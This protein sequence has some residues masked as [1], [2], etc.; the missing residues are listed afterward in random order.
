[1]RRLLVALGL[2]AATLAGSAAV[3][4]AAGPTGDAATIAYVRAVDANADAQRA[5]QVTQTGYMTFTSEGGPSPTFSYQWGFGVV[6]VG[7]V[8]AAELITFAQHLGTV[9][10]VTDVLTPNVTRCTASRSC[11]S[12]VPL[13]L[14]VT[15][16]AAF[17]GLLDGPGA[18]VSCFDREPLRNVPYRAGGRWWA[19]V[20]D[21]RPMVTRGNQRL[22]TDTY[23][24]ADGQ[25]VTEHDSIDVAS[26]LFAAATYR[27]GRGVQPGAVAFSFAQ[28]DAP[29]AATPAAP[30]VHLCP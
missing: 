28:H 29:L 26:R 18:T 15:R 21:Y 5:M 4:L 19:A 8:P 17:A 9:V 20:G 14:L 11:A 12:I 7:S 25:H 23:A 27:V 22:V 1:M 6:P 13:E 16:K 10:W 30:R 3:A 2:C 24:W